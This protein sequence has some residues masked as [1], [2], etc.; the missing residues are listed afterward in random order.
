MGSGTGL[1]ALLLELKVIE[2]ASH[3]T[4]KNGAKRHVKDI[5]G[6]VIEAPLQGLVRLGRILTSRKSSDSLIY[7][8]RSHQVLDPACPGGSLYEVSR[9]ST[10][11]KTPQS[12]T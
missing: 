7:R 10:C 2:L 8:R 9:P 4:H 3:P 11:L 6:R 1:V 12:A 5:K